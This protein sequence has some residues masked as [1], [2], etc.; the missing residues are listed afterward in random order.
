MNYTDTKVVSTWSHKTLS[1]NSDT[2]PISKKLPPHWPTPPLD[3]A[4]NMC[5]LLHRPRNSV[6]YIYMYR[7]HNNGKNS[8]TAQS[9]CGVHLPY[10]NS[11]TLPLISAGSSADLFVTIFIPSVH[12]SCTHYLVPLDLPTLYPHPPKKSTPTLFQC[13]QKK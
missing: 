2:T 10:S 8:G 5:H 7:H 6:Q 11:T 13:T 1:I 4:S 9:T 3:W 12:V